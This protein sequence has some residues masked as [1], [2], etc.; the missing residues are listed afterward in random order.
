MRPI[1]LKVSA[2]GPYAGRIDIP[3]DELGSRGLYLITGDT[4][5]GKTTIFDAI[6][7]A[8]YGE[9]SGPNRDSTMFRS[10]YAD[11]D[12]PTEVE[13]TFSHGDKEYYVRRNPEYYRP[14]KSG[15]GFTKQT[16]DAELHMPDGRIYTKV[17]EVTAAIEEILGI[18]KEQFSQIAMIAQGDFLKLLL[19]DTKQ[20]QEIFRELFKTQPY[21]ML[22]LRLED[23]R[24][25][26]YGQAEDGKKSIEQYIKGIQADSDDVLFIEVQKAQRGAM[27]TGD[28]LELLD[29]LNDKDVSLKDKLEEELKGIG[30]ELE[31]TNKKIGAGQELEK[32]KRAIEEGKL[33]LKE[34]E[35][36]LDLATSTFNAAKEALKEKT[37][38][39]KE[40]NI[41]EAALCDYDAAGK[42]QGEIEALKEEKLKQGRAL[43]EK[44][45]IKREKSENLNKLKDEL[46][47]YKDTS[48]EM[49]KIKNRIDKIREESDAADDLSESLRSYYDDVKAYQ[50]ALEDYK[51]KDELFNN[52]NR[53]YELKEQAF[54]D[55]QAGILAQKLKEGEKCPVCGSISHPLPAK[56]SEAVPTEKELKA[57]KDESINA[58]KMREASAKE[59]GGLKKVIDAQEE[60]LKKRVKKL[61]GTESI[62][63]A[64]SNINDI[65][66]SYVK[67]LAQEKEN[68]TKEEA[69]VKRKVTLDKLIPSLEE[70]IE[71][72]TSDIAKITSFIAAE[73]A[74]TKEKEEQLLKLKKE[75]GFANKSEALAV[76]DRF[77]KQAEAV[78]KSYDYAN[79]ALSEQ[80]EKVL[81]LKTAIS[82]NE[83]VLEGAAITDLEGEK[84]K[85]EELNRK[86]EESIARGKIVA[87]RLKN[88][89]TIHANIMAKAVGIDETEKKLQ[90]VKALSDTANG[91]IS[92]KD[93]VMLETYIQTTYFDRIISRAN[94][95]LITMSGGQ[96]ELIRI[97]EAANVKSQ[98]GLDLGVIDH[99]NGSK[100]SVKTLSGGESFMASLS[101][102]L[103]LSDEVQ[104][105]AGGIKIDTMFVDE[106]FGSLDPEA[107]DMAYKALAGLTEGDRLVGIISHVADLKERIDKQI[108]V[109]KEKSGGS[110]IKML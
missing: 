42:L 37:A 67:R 22:Q 32:A 58:R 85:K 93:K 21:Q 19:A 12:T 92:G 99:Y 68:F 100:R 98:S 15:E 36:E 102:A 48:A 51:N 3:M 83:K 104:S 66:E 30:V 72:C 28:V 109:I 82:E 16:A 59:A 88:N 49:E 24:K 77:I 55:G 2:F 8:L 25:E 23:K 40:A 86:Q 20:R 96:Y 31:E 47:A 52:S 94:L 65:K 76:R 80:K 17:K 75:L 5:A 53:L 39:E 89:E 44:E 87:A 50:A 84:I 62:D 29:K 46:L 9:A 71:K 107:L 14:K 56:I 43:E 10:K 108:V 63:E 11:E 105:S 27:T 97:K 7:F 70:E 101:L 1:D 78:Q 90:W 6:C 106:G 74:K 34:A 4:G 54:Y 13:L 61:L 95:R 45:K 35:P 60:E 91:K 41:I 110:R 57:A 33:K 73:D 38:A 103:G 18:N 69:K 64:W 26:I 79:A 81:K